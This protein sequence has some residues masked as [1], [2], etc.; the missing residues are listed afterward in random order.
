MPGRGGARSQASMWTEITTP[1]GREGSVLGPRCPGLGPCRGA[2]VPRLHSVHIRWQL[3]TQSQIRV[4]GGDGE[5]SVGGQS[6]ELTE[7][8]A[9][10]ESGSAPAG[11]YLPGPPGAEL[12]EGEVRGVHRRSLGP[13]PSL[14]IIPAGFFLLNLPS[15]HFRNSLGYAVLPGAP[16]GIRSES[17]SAV[18]MLAL[19]PSS[20]RFRPFVE[21]GWRVL[22]VFYP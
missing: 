15:P 1:C 8:A 21:P 5:W 20:Q 10:Q 6:G 11:C 4:P 9:G 13:L 12:E 22:S 18:S 3:Q 16:T 17:C 19:H 14:P 7:L 2:A